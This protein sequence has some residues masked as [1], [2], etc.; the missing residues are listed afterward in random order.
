MVRGNHLSNDPEDSTKVGNPAANPLPTQPPA[1]SQP[2]GLD[3]SSVDESLLSI[4]DLDALLSEDEEFTR[5][6]S[7]LGPNEE[8]MM[9]LDEDDFAIP[10]DFSEERDYWKKARG[11][12][13]RIYRVFPPIF[14]FS[15]IWRTL[16]MKYGEFKVR[17][18]DFVINCG[19]NTLKL[20]K[21][22]VHETRESISEAM[23]SF[24]YFK[25]LKKLAVFGLIFLVIGSAFVVYRVS[26]KG[27]LPAPEELFIGSMEDWSQQKFSY[28]PETESEAFYESTHNT[29]NM[30]SLTKMVVNLKRS[31]GSGPN[32]MAAFEF[33]VEG[34]AA[35]VLVEI[36]D[37]EGEVRDLFQRNMEDMNYDQVSSPEGKQLLTEKLRKEVNKILSKGKVRRVY[38][39]TVLIKP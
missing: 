33:Y 34:T 39:K 19:P 11:R 15:F 30:I 25:P 2:L 7:Q 16:R 1:T 38:I 28:S 18:L 23:R 24:R 26:T 35:D 13:G 3:E 36:K 4:E 8:I 32:P 31:A 6:L 12:R 20:I 14:V 37:R 9:G 17:A 10:Q 27:L 29:Q 21:R 5:S 22:V